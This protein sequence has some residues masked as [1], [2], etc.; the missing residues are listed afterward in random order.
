MSS[1]SSYEVVQHG[2]TL[3]T[4]AGVLDGDTAKGHRL[5]LC[6]QIYHMGQRALLWLWRCCLYM[7]R[8]QAPLGCQRD[9]ATGAIAGGADGLGYLTDRAV[10]IG[11]EI[12]I[13]G[14]S[15]LGGTDDTQP[16]TGERLGVELQTHIH[17]LPCG[18]AEALSGRLRGVHL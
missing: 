18:R 7:S 11:H 10:V 13:Y 9:G 6:A 4:R 1:P 17:I 15:M 5:Y 2:G 16:I 8:Q 12:E 14:L 3:A